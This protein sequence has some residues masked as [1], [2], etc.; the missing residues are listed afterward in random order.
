MFMRTCSQARI[1]INGAK[2]VAKTAVPSL[3][4]PAA[5]PIKFCSAIPTFIN[6]SGYSVTNLAS[7]DETARS[8]V[9]T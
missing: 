6:L 1:V 2:D 7:P 3:A 8:A 5:I 9:T 4:K